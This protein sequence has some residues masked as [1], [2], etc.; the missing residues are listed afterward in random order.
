MENLSITPLGTVSPYSKGKKNCPGFLIN[1]KDNKIVLDCGSGI[2][3]LLNFPD[4]LHDLSVIISHLHKDHFSDLFS[5]CYASHVYN[6]VGM[7][8]EKVNIY[9][10]SYPKDK[11]KYIKDFEENGEHHCLFN[12]YSGSTDIYIDGL[13]ISFRENPHGILS[14]SIKLE[15]EAG[16]IVYSGDTGYKLN[17]LTKFAKGADLLI[18]EST[19]LKG[20]KRTKDTHLYASEAAKI[21]KKAKVRQLMLTH[22]WPEI[23]RKKY[24]EEAKEVFE[25]TVAAKE[26]MKLTLQKKN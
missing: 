3:R 22:F 16:T 7:L 21:A 17:S 11:Y 19:F 14:H 4:D 1:H 8:D 5:I 13:R 10:P 20:Q 15:S 9:L 23:K 6:N 2:T 18:C 26:G 25:N 24:V 12:S